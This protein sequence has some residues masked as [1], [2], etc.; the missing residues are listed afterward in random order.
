MRSP[1]VIWFN[2][3]MLGVIADGQLGNG[4]RRVVSEQAVEQPVPAVVTRTQDPRH[5]ARTVQGGRAAA[6]P[7]QARGEDVKETKK[8]K[9]AGK[10]KADKKAIKKQMVAVRRVGIIRTPNQPT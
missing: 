1:S 2:T 5:R 8:K 9:A 6:L 3:P 10:V 7:S 4:F